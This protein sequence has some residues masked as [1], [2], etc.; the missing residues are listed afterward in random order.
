MAWRWHER[1]AQEVDSMTTEPGTD[2]APQL[3]PSLRDPEAQKWVSEHMADLRRSVSERRIRNQTLWLVL[4]TGLIAYVAGYLLKVSVTSEP[5][6]LLADLIY[7][8]GYVLWTGVVVVVVIEIIPRAKERQITRA[9]ASYE[10]VMRAKAA[11]PDAP[12]DAASD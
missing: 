10:A 2:G 6:G 9:L 4:A 12:S 11:P 5:W 1:F 8:L 7:T 3:D